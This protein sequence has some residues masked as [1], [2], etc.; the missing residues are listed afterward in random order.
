M[1]NDTQIAG[2]PPAAPQDLKVPEKGPK[3]KGEALP[4]TGS[5][6][7]MLEP[8]NIEETMA[9]A[10]LL[11]KSD[12]VPKDFQGKPA[13]IVVAVTLGREV[14]FGWAQALQTIAVINGRPSIWGDGAIG[15]ILASGFLAEQ[16]DD[17]DPKTDGGTATYRCRRHGSK[18]FIV[19]SFSMNDA[20][21]AGL[22]GK[23]T[24]QKYGPRMC[25][26]RARS[27]ALR[28]G[29][30]DVLKGLR[31]R[32]EEDDVIILNKT[33]SGDYAAPGRLSD[34]KPK[35][36]APTDPEPEPTPAPAEETQEGQVV[37]A[38]L[39]YVE[40]VAKN[41]RTG[42]YHVLI[43]DKDFTAT[44]AIAKAAH[45]LM[46]AKKPVDFSA[47]ESGILTEIQE[48]GPAAD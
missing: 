7:K 2:A 40:S 23:D 13:N 39:K 28:D 10:N 32:E 36:Q 44:E 22:T 43:G 5:F 26:N 35:P 16:A 30:A 47:T 3:F 45:S 17:W 24:Y 18:E 11:S 14:G 8:R 15:L 42:E 27:W 48:V 9:L 46:E 37:D 6:A 31:I 21:R 34:P 19:R 29:F 41:K 38:E 12:I 33:P 4:E 1:G 25:F 20:K